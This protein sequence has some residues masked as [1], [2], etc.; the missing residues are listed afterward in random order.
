MIIRGGKFTSKSA[1]AAI[2]NYGVLNITGGKGSSKSGYSAIIN[3]DGGVIHAKNDNYV[4]KKKFS[5]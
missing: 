2:A 1:S 5:F 3:G 4:D